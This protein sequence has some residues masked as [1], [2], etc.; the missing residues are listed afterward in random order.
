MTTIKSG[1]VKY[2]AGR[3]F[4]DKYKQGAFKQ[5]LV[6][7]M[8]DGSEETLWFTQG[9]TPHSTLPKGAAVQLLYEPK[10]DGKVIRKLVTHSNST[11]T[12]QTQSTV[13]SAEQKRAIA[14]YV[15]QQGDVLVYCWD[16]ALAKFQQKVQTEE[17]LRQ[18]ATTLYLSAK[19]R[20]GY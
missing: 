4:P 17:S 14:E 13:L 9:R 12:A 19:D 20:F 10:E 2:P 8:S 7:T 6:L 5:N 3:A 11:P 1:I 16:T 18:L 15:Q